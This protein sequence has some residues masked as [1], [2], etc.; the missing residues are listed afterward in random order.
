LR[1]SLAES[2]SAVQ[3]AAPKIFGRLPHLIPDSGGLADCWLEVGFR[4]AYRDRNPR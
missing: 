2:Q 1:D 4:I 3:S